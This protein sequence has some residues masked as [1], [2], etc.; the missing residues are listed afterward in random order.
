MNPRESFATVKS[1]KPNDLEGTSGAV[2]SQEQI[3]GQFSPEEQKLIRERMRVLSLIPNHIGK[4]FGMEVELN[5][6]GEGWHWNFAIN[7][8]RVDP[9]DLLEKPL[10]WCRHT[11][12]HEGGHRRVS[13]TDFIPKNVWEQP[14]FSSMINAI[15][16]KLGVPPSEAKEGLELPLA[17][18]ERILGKESVLGPKDIEQVFGKKIEAP[19]IQFPTAEL[20]KA[21]ELGQQ[22]IFQTDRM[23]VKN[24]DTGKI[25]RTVPITLENLKKYFPKAHDDMP[26]WY[27]QDWYTNEDFFKKEKPRTGW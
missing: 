12:A 8:V 2:D 5:A 9:K 18:A 10:D 19:R 26:T 11:M 27:S 13:R 22:L 24:P 20:E 21:K 3:F 6:P 7:H 17:D 14:G 15:E 1:S 4:D 16:E 23:D 25:E